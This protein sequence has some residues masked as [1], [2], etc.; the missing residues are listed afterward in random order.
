MP[1]QLIS[2]TAAPALTAPAVQRI[3]RAVQRYLHLPKQLM[4]TVVTVNRSVIRQLNHQYRAQ[5]KVTDVLSFAYDEK[6][7]EV[8]VCYPQAVAQAH[9]KQ[10]P[11]TRE[12]AWLII[13]GILHV[14]GYDHDAPADALAMRAL[15]AKIL[16][17]V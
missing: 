7:G 10:N 8:V 4:I 2:K 3:Y 12:L 6:H 16:A 5:N 9:A 11:L 13:H 15:E 14:R 1:I 17:Y